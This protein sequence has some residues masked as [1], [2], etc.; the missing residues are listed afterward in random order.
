VAPEDPGADEGPA[1]L[2]IRFGITPLLD[3]EIDAGGMGWVG[4]TPEAHHDLRIEVTSAVIGQFLG[5]SPR[6]ARKYMVGVS[7]HTPQDEL[8]RQL[9]RSHMYQYDQFYQ[10][11][12]VRDGP[13]GVF[14]F[15]LA[16]VRSRASIE[17]MLITARQGFLIEPCLIARSLIEQF[18][19]A[20]RVWETDDDSVIFD[21]KPQSLIK[22]LY[23]SNSHAGRAYG[24]LSK[25]C[26]YDPKMH[27]AFIGGNQ[28]N[29]K[30][31][32]SG[33]VLQRSWRFKITALTWVFFILD[34]KFQ[35]FR[36]CY[37][38]HPNFENLNKSEPP[39]RR[40]FEEFFEGVDFPAVREMRALLT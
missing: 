11:I 8:L 22:Y 23:P 29:W 38:N 18:A 7:Q 33:T 5:V 17:L 9:C 34:L 32:E 13:L 15:D 39:V 37:G 12:G 30:D 40:V 4:L 28:R 35:I 14:A 2:R 10:T 26:H 6:T 27:Y 31:E 16:M 1:D 20:V 21:S 24:M 36:R 3:T 25:L 19:Y